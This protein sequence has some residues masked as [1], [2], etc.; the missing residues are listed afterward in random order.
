MTLLIDPRL[1]PQ[2]Q[3]AIKGG[4]FDTFMGF[5]TTSQDLLSTPE[6]LAHA[7]TACAAAYRCIRLRASA[8]AGI[9]IILKNAQG[10]TTSHP[11]VKLLRDVN[12][13]TMNGYDLFFATEAAQCLWGEAFWLKIR[14][15]GRSLQWLQFLAPPTMSIEADAHQGVTRYVQEVDNLKRTFVP[16]DIIHFLEYHPLSDVGGLSPLS[17]ALS[18]INAEINA[19]TFVAAFFANDARPAGLLTTDQAL[20]EHDIE[21]TSRWWER[22][23]KGV[24]NRWKTGIVGG[25]LSYQHIAYAP[26]DLALPELRREDRIVIA[27]AFEVPPV[28]A[29]EWSDLPYASVREQTA[30][31]YESTIIPQTRKYCA[32]LDYSYL[33][34]FPDI[35]HTH[36]F[37]PDLSRVPALKETE[38]EKA[39]RLRSLVEAQIITRE[40]ARAELGYP[41]EPLGEF[42]DLDRP[43]DNQS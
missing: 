9:P 29:G 17:V 25:G 15:P 19:E 42:H 8:I 5:R 16:T 7:Y 34:E 41:A 39:G 20:S 32:Y 26:K 43:S 28:F 2:T 38:G 35:A 24:S 13:W 3:A 40:E 33:P 11:A 30:H 14:T 4:L 23:F 6:G 1:P 22:L 37:E 10:A 21:Q 27:N 12:P 31:F 18:A 36:H